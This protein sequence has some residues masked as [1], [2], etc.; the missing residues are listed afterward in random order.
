MTKEEALRAEIARAE[1]MDKDER[2]VVY[3]T[4]SLNLL[5]AELKRERARQ[6]HRALKDALDS[7]GVKRVR[8]ALGGVYYE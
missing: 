4:D 8:G 5:R 2:I 3:G 7:I 1:A 6:R